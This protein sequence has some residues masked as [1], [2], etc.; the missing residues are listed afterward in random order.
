MPAAAAAAAP[1]PARGQRPDIEAK[2][3]LFDCAARAHNKY[4]D[5][6][7]QKRLRVR[8]FRTLERNGAASLIL[9]YGNAVRNAMEQVNVTETYSNQAQQGMPS[10]S[11]PGG[12]LSVGREFV[13]RPSVPIISP[14]CLLSVIFPPQGYRYV[15]HHVLL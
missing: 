10:N 8:Q 5:R 13:H 15:F 14:G 6:E 9:E 3:R 12:A 7:T 1:E 4:L 2:R 11:K